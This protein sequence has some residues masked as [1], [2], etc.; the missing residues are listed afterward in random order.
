MTRTTGA[1]Q[2]AAT[3]AHRLIVQAVDVLAVD[4]DRVAGQMDG[5]H[6]ATHELRQFTDADLADV[7]ACCATWAARLVMR[8]APAGD[9]DD[10]W[11][12]AQTVLY[13]EDES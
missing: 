9:S 2:D 7:A 6:A 13:D 3:I 11:L 5:L 1:P 8:A 10:Q 4:L 12:W